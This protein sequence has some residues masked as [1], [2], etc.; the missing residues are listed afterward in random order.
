MSN[1]CKACVSLST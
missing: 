1:T